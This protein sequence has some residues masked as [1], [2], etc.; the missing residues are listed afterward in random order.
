MIDGILFNNETALVTDAADL[1]LNHSTTTFRALVRG[2]V[3][4][5]INLARLI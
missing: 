3:W 1:I 2:S 5:S 4:W